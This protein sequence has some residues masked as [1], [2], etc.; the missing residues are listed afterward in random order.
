MD[1]QPPKFKLQL[2][3]KLLYINQSNVTLI[4]YDRLPFLSTLIRPVLKVIIMPIMH[5]ARAVFYLYFDLV[6]AAILVFRSVSHIIANYCLV[7]KCLANVF[8][9]VLFFSLSVTN[10][11]SVC[12]DSEFSCCNWYLNRLK[13]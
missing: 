6:V 13:L 5:K 2:H 9:K 8:N 7:L 10:V 4:K 11:L 3:Y 1:I 12:M